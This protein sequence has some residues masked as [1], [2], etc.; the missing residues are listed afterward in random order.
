MK[1][2]KIA[3]SW[4]VFLL[5][6]A[7]LILATG[8]AVVGIL[9]LCAW[10]MGITIGYWCI[11]AALALLIVCALVFFWL[12]PLKGEPMVKNKPNGVAYKEDR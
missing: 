6:C 3:L 5:G 8:G 7:L 9:H 11:P 1:G 12:N 10:V 4:V 2:L